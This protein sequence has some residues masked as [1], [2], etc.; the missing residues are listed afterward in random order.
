MR[1]KRIDK[2]WGYEL[3]FARTDRYAGKVI[4]IQQGEC[5]S[6]QYHRHK[7][8]TLYLH[9]GRLR[10]VIDRGGGRDELDLHAGEVVHLPPGTCHRFEARETSVLF[11]VSTPELDD[12]VRIDD[13]YGRSDG[14]DQTSGNT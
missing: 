8:E 3:L 10:L 7:E 14:P 11:E 6:Y 9:E 5:L 4:V 13:R 12:V 2:P 1:P